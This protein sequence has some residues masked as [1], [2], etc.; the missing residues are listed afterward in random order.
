MA[1]FQSLGDFG[2]R[3]KG[4]FYKI[5]PLERSRPTVKELDHLCT[6]LD[7][8]AQVLDGGLCQAL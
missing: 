1:V 7:L 4:V 2:R 8:F 5:L 3:V 6:R